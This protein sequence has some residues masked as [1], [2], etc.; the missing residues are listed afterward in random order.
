[1]LPAGNC[2]MYLILIYLPFHVVEL[3]RRDA[4]V[5]VVVHALH[6]FKHLEDALLRH[7]GNKQNGEIGER[8]QPFTDCIRVRI[9]DFL[10]LFFNQIPFVHADHQT[11]AVLL[12]EREDVQVL[13][14]DAPLRIQHED[15]DVGILDRADGTDDGIIFQILVHLALLADPGCPAFGRPT[16]AIRGSSS[17]TSIGFSSGMTS[18]ILSN[19]SPVHEPLMAEMQIGSPKPNA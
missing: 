16:M 9:D 17:S 3:R 7:R 10:V 18:K 1:M 11:L 19:K 5:A 13:A 8:S 14:L 2:V 4:P 12:D 15:A 6:R